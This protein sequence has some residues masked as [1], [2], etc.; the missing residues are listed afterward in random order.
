MRGMPEE[1]PAGA[2]GRENLF[3]TM[4]SKGLS[5]APIRNKNRYG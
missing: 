4:S 5:E 2:G 3:V 1:L